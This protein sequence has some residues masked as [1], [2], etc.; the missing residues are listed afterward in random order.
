MKTNDYGIGSRP[1]WWM[2]TSEAIDNILK[3]DMHAKKVNRFN[4]HPANFFL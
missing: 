4:C 2:N 3:I 1:F